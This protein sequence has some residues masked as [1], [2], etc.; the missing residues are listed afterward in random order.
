MIVF[1]S[2]GSRTR[3]S[4]G[5]DVGL[6]YTDEPVPL[7]PPNVPPPQD[8]TGNDEDMPGPSGYQDS[9]VPDENMPYDD[10]GDDSPDLGGTGG[11][12]FGPG[13]SGNQGENDP[14][15]PSGEIEFQYGP[16]GN[17]SP[18]YPGGGAAIP[19][20]EDS[21]SSMELIP[22]GAFGGANPHP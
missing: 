17:P 21:D 20:P 19:V 3:P 9:M 13:P 18:H 22:D 5:P 15:L 14:D 4:T 12:P 1:W 6:D 11:G 7:P 2:E 16:G 10:T 8:G